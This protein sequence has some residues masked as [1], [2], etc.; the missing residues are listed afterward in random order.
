MS[1]ITAV[2]LAAGRGSRLQL[3]TTDTPKCLVKVHDR[4]IID[5]A[6][7]AL[8]TAGIEK[9]VVVTGYLEQLVCDYV[10]SKWSLTGLK[11]VNNPHFLQTGTAQSLF[12]GIAAIE[13]DSDL[14]II[15]GD[16]VFEPNLLARLVD[17]P[18]EIV[19]LL[20]SYRSDLSGTFVLIEENDRVVDWLHASHQSETFAPQAHF[21]TVNLH[22]FCNVPVSR[23]LVPTLASTL[24]EE[25]LQAPLEYAMR[26]IV[27]SGENVTARLVDDLR[28]YEID[29]ELDLG[30]ARS[31]MVGSQL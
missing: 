20:Q 7:Q 8:R 4:A 18:G 26:R 17:S 21:K 3:H 14:L 16:V 13:K 23:V 12:L 6:I 30:R 11:F 31:I 9:L 22:R 28:W 2:I 25:G 5:Y 27:Q 1:Q 19:T 24:I 29:D 10:R 15:E